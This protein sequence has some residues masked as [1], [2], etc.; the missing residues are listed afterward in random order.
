MLPDTIVLGILLV[1]LFGAL[2]LAL[3]LGGT[4]SSSR[5]SLGDEPDEVPSTHR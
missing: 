4:A 2:T 3:A 5:P 1:T